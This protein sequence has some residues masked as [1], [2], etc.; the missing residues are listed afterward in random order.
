MKRSISFIIILSV[1]LVQCSSSSIISSWQASEKLNVKT[2]RV[3]VVGLIKESDKSLQWQME[4]HLADDLCNLG[5]D[6]I[7]SIE[8]YGF[9]AFKGKDEKEIIKQLEQDDI[10]AVLTIVLLN[11]QK[12][13]YYALKSMYDLTD[14]YN[15]NDFSVYYN[16]IYTKIY[17]EGYYVNDTYYFWES[18]LFTMPGQKLEYSVQTQSFNPLNTNSLAHEYGKLIIQDML[19]NSIIQSSHKQKE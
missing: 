15:D 7:P 9:K 11:K 14:P 1:F 12:E 6:A 19:S 3:V 16:A 5:Y 8:L 17:Q 4:N 2:G 18:N 10:A 13:K